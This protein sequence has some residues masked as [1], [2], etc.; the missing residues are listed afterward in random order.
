MVILTTLGIANLGHIFNSKIPQLNVPQITWFQDW[1]PVV[2]LKLTESGQ[3]SQKHALQDGKFHN[4]WF[5]NAETTLISS[6]LIS[7]TFLCWHC[8]QILSPERRSK[9][10]GFDINSP[11]FALCSCIMG[12]F[13]EI[14][15]YFQFVEWSNANTSKM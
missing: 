12:A 10:L 1:K 14:K 7:T 15:D 4:W 13:M 8:H 9:H 5:I 11:W 6:L 2:T 3:W